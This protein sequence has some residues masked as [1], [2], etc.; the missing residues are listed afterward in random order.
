LRKRSTAIH[1]S[2]QTAAVVLVS[3]AFAVGVLCL[4]AGAGRWRKLA[5]RRGAR[6]ETLDTS[7]PVERQRVF[8]MAAELLGPED[9]RSLL[10]GVLDAPSREHAMAELNQWLGDAR[11][12]LAGG[13]Q[14]A[15]SAGRV[16]L[17]AGTLLA[18]IEVARSLP[19][20][21][22]SVVGAFASFGFGVAAALGTSIFGRLADSRA[23]RTRQRWSR[24]VRELTRRWPFEAGAAEPS[25]AHAGAD[26]AR[27]DAEG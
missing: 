20:G 22:T 13:A 10:R 1:S 6:P 9:A 8:R 19:S 12:Q 18:L 14:V 5:P 23:D 26:A 24:L 16:A 11:H 7:E 25:P 15:R 4:V 21:E 27:L 17:A 3:M 2:P